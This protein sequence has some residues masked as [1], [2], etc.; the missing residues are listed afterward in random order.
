[1]LLHALAIWRLEDWRAHGG[2]IEEPPLHSTTGGE[3][4]LEGWYCAEMNGILSCERRQ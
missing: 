3:K 2:G 4:V 1:M